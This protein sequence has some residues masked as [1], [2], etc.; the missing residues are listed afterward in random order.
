MQ[1]RY[2]H[3]EGMDLAGKT[4]ATKALS[5]ILG[6]NCKTRRNTL[7]EKSQFH[8]IIDDLR[9]KDGLGEKELGLLYCKVLEDDLR[10]FEYPTQ[11]T[12][13]DST[14][15]LRSLSYHSAYEN[16][17][18]VDEF[19]Q[20]LPLHPKFTKSM[21]LTADLDSRLKRLE[22]RKAMNPEEIAKDDLM[23]ITDPNRFFLMEK[24]LIEYSQTHFDAKVIDTSDL[25]KERVLEKIL[26]YFSL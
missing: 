23:I 16:W 9:I 11:N 6:N 19:K 1:V 20:L 8:K 22:M 26:D 17:D 5:M 24:Y 3:I 2:F 12:I 15:L 18:L 14:V 13:Q 10:K 7:Q 25:D 4:S 21:V